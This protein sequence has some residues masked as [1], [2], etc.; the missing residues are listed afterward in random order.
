MKLKWI[1]S[2]Q[3]WKHSKYISFLLQSEVCEA[4]LGG[5]TCRVS[6]ILYICIILN[7]LYSDFIKDNLFLFTIRPVNV[8]EGVKKVIFK[9]KSG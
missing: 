5:E 7:L 8:V 9:K 4:D 6:G 3:D 1:K 2:L